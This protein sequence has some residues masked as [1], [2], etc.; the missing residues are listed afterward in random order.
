MVKT[1][2]QGPC[3]HVNGSPGQRA[4]KEIHNKYIITGCDER[5]VLREA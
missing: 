1:H 2:R 4:I 3:P 5:S